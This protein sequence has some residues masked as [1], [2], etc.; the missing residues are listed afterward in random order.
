MAMNMERKIRVLVVCIHPLLCE[1]IVR[2]LTE[3]AEF[4]VVGPVQ[5]LEEALEAN[6]ARPVDVVLLAGENPGG[7]GSLVGAVLESMPQAAMLEARLSENRL[8][9][10][11]VREAPASKDELFGA[12]RALSSSN[13]S[14][15]EHP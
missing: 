14:F 9:F 2:L 1:G 15:F 4:E 10:Y 3:S 5:S 8:R 6:V 11:L 7:Q 13:R 12:L